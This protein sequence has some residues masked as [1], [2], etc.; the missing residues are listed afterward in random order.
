MMMEMMRIVRLHRAF[1]RWTTSAEI[2]VNMGSVVVDDDNHSVG[3]GYFFC[4]GSR[5]GFLQQLT[6]PRNFLRTKI[7]CLR[8]L[9]KNAFVAH[10]E[11]EFIA[12]MWLHLA[13]VLNQFERLDPT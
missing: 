8:L 12:S 3:L 13:Q 7:V 10:A 1:V 5:S 4:V 11:N 6:Q 9:E 2:L